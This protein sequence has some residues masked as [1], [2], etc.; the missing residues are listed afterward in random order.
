MTRPT[1]PADCLWLDATGA[2]SMLSQSPR[3]FREKTAALPGF[4]V[5]TRINGVGD[6]RWRAS[7]INDW[8]LAQRERTAP[9]RQRA[10]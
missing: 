5:P 9:G 7:E 10:A 4:P 2:A 6:P 8:M 1:V 3:Y